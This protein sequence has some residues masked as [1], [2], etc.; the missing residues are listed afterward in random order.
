MTRTI[1]ASEVQPGMKIRFDMDGWDVEGVVSRIEPV[2][3]GLEFYS[4]QGVE[5]TL[6]EDT[7]VT[8]L[9]EPQPEE[10]AAFGARVVAGEYKALRRNGRAGAIWSWV[11]EFPGGRTAPYSW[12]E[13]CALGQVTVIDADP[14]WTVPED[15]PT[16]APVV[17]ER[18]EEWPEDDAHLREQ[19]WRDRGGTVWSSRDGQWGYHSFTMGWVGLVAP[20]RY[21][22][23]GPWVRVP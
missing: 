15:A 20:Y 13:V 4:T 19:R 14:Y 16:E 12:K 1:K 6:G 23:N 22:F 21:P 18:I 8:V 3:V 17:P 11:V 5:M 9:A 2:I 7:L 10:P